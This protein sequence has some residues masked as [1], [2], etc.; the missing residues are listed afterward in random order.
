MNAYLA[1]GLSMDEGLCV[2]YTIEML[3]MLEAL[4]AAGMVHGDFKPDNLL[5]RDNDRYN[6]TRTSKGEWSVRSMGTTPPG[7]LWS[8]QFGDEWHGDVAVCAALSGTSGVGTD[9]AAGL[10]RSVP[11]H[12]PPP[13]RIPKPETR[14]P[15]PET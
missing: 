10:T 2:F 4:H 13:P 7:L 3:R 5:L 15:N 8:V 14:N 6:P 12:Q 9:P 1:K 11:A